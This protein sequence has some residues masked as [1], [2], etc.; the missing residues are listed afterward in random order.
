MLIARGSRTFGRASLRWTLTFAAEL[1]YSVIER[2]RLM[3]DTRF[4]PGVDGPRRANGCLYL[5]LRGTFEPHGGRR[6]DGPACL[7]LSEHQLEGANGAR[8]FTYRAGGESFASIQLNLPLQHLRVAPADVPPVPKLSAATWK[9]AERIF[10]M[11]REEGDEAMVTALVE[12]TAQLADD[13]LVAAA[14]RGLAAQPVPSVFARIWQAFRPL[15]E[16]FSLTPT[17]QELSA[18]SAIPLRRVERHLRHFIAS[19]GHLA[20]GWRPATKHTRV[21][22]AVMLLSAEDLAIGDVAAAV[23]YGS[24]DAMARAFRDLG[25]G[26]PSSVR[27]GIRDAAA[28]PQASGAGA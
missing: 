23:G 19:T 20:A 12:L 17:V 8:P 14:A 15:I 1:W 28:S 21:K 11:Q 6:I 27:D 10:E 26:A 7:V 18:A 16:N 3:L 5:L 4:L 22:L 13:G 9:S 2:E 24:T 25:L